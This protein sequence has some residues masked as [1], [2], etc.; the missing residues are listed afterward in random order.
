MANRWRNIVITPKNINMTPA[1]L[2][3]L[4][5]ITLKLW[6][7]LFLVYQLWQFRLTNLQNQV[8]MQIELFEILEQMQQ[9]LKDQESDDSLGVIN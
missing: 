1:L 8:K 3:I 4:I 2:T 6:F 5:L 9:S 7:I